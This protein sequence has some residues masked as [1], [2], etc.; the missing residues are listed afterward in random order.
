[1]SNVDDQLSAGFVTT[2]N[3]RT[4]LAEKVEL[5]RDR[6][7]D[8]SNR[9]ALI[10]TRISER[11]S[12]L[13]FDT[14]STEEIWQKL[15]AESE[16][17]ADPMRFPW[18]RDLVPPPPDWQEYEEE[19][20][21]VA[22][23]EGPVSK[24]PVASDESAPTTANSSPKTDNTSSTQKQTSNGSKAESKT[25]TGTIKSSAVSLRKRKRRE[26]NPPFEECKS[27]SLLQPNDL[28]VDKS[29]KVLDRKLR[30]LDS[31]ARLAMSEQGVH[32]LYVAFG[33]LKWYES[34][35]SSDARFSPLMLVPVTLSRDSTSAPWELTEA[36]DDVVSNLCLQ[37]RLWQ[38]FKLEL[39]K[40]PEINELEEEGA[41]K[42][43]LDT[44]A[45][46]IE[47]HERW[48]VV[49]KCL[50][51]RFAF[52]K[53]VMWEDLGAHAE[54]VVEHPLCRAIG[55]DE[56]AIGPQAFGSIGEAPPAKELDDKIS[57]GEIK[58][59]LDCDSSQL[60]AIVAARKGI[61]FVLDGPPGTGKS[62]TIANI[63]A[64]AL[65]VG[66]T[67]LFVS[68]KISALEVVKQRLQ[69]CQLDDFCLECH[70]DKASRRAVLFELERCLDLQQEKYPDW[71]PKLDELAEQRS[72][73]NEYV[74]RIHQPREPLGLSAFMLYGH[75][76]RLMNRGLAQL[77]QCKLPELIDVNRSTFDRWMR[78]LGRASDHQEV[79][80]NFAMHPWRGCKQTTRSLSIH[81]QVKQE[82][83][84][85]SEKLDEVSRLL[86][87]L[88]T[89]ELVGPVTIGNINDTIKACSY[90]ISVPS[91][92]DSWFVAPAETAAA[93]S[94]L[95][96]NQARRTA[97]LNELDQFVDDVEDCFPVDAAKAFSDENSPEVPQ[98]VQGRPIAKSTL[99][100]ERLAEVEQ[101]IARLVPVGKSLRELDEALSE[102]SQL[103]GLS[104]SSPVTSQQLAELGKAA[105]LAGNAGPA[106]P[107]WFSSENRK[108]IRPLAENAET[109]ATRNA[110]L[111]ER[112][113]PVI[114]EE[115]LPV[116]IS[117]LKDASDDTE[118]FSYA[119]D[120]KL[121][122][123]KSLEGAI[124]NLTAALELIDTISVAT[125]QVVE[126][127]GGH[128]STDRAVKPTATTERL[129]AILE[130]IENSGY[131]CCTWRDASVRDSLRRACE[132]AEAD[133]QDATKIRESLS[134]RM[135]HRAFRDSSHSLAKR[136]NDFTSSWSRWSSSFKKYRNELT[137]LYTASVPKG[138]SV[139]EDMALLQKYHS[140]VLEVRELAEELKPHLPQDFISAEP[141]SW[142]Q[143]KAAVTAFSELATVWPDLVASLANGYRSISP[144]KLT[145]PAKRM[146]DALLEYRHLE[147]EKRLGLPNL[148]DEGTSSTAEVLTS[149]KVAFEKVKSQWDHFDEYTLRPIA[150]IAE[151]HEFSTAL[152]KF[153]K[154]RSELNDAAE[155]YANWLPEDSSPSHATTWQAMK[156]GIDAAQLFHSIGVTEQQLRASWGD[157][158]FTKHKMSWH[159]AGKRLENAWEAANAALSS[160]DVDSRGLA[161]G[162][163]AKAVDREINASKAAKA[164][165]ESVTHALRA[166]GNVEIDELA[167]IADQILE[168]REARRAVELAQTKLDNLEV[169]EVAAGDLEAAQWLGQAAADETLSP[170][171]RAV[172]SD[173][174]IRQQVQEILIESRE[175]LQSDGF[176]QAWDL[177][178]S[179]FDLN[180]EVSDGFTISQSSPDK[181]SEKLKWLTTQMSCFDS[182][183]NFAS[184]KR[185][186][187]E[188]G[189]GTVVDELVAQRYK[190]EDAADVIA[191]Q[192]YRQMFDC[193]AQTERAIG[194]FDVDEHERIRERFRF[195]DQ[196]EIKTSASRIR[197]YQLSRND[198]PTNNFWGADSSELGILL[199][200]IAK[201][202]KHK[203]LR[204]LFTEIPTV[205]QR[206]KPCIMMSP[207]SVSTFLNT[208]LLRFDL[209][210]F[211]EASQ[212]F[213]WD[214][215]GAVYR[216]QQLIVAGDD[217]QLPPTNF[218]SRADAETDE[219]EE[220]I[221]DYESILSLCKSIGMPNQRL[222]WH[223]RS[224]REPLIAF[225][226]RHFYDGELVTFPSIYDA[227]GDGVR[228]E[229]VPDG[230][231]MDSKNLKEAERIV[232]MIVE[233]V[234]TRPDK[235][236]GVIALNR[237][238]QK[239]IEDS[240]YDLRRQD[241]EI[242]ALFD[243]GNYF[244]NVAER[245]FVKNLENV[246][247]DER[248]VIFLSMGFGY[249]D[250]G[251]FLKNFG[252]IIRPNGER[253]LNVAV[254]RAREELVFVS[255]VRSSDMDLSGSKSEGA[256]LLKAYL[257]YAEKGVDTLGHAIDEFSAEMD[258]PFEGEV[259]AALI[260][261]GF[262]PV[263]QVGCGGF[264]IDLALKHPDRPGEFCLAIECDGSTY[265]SSDTARDRDRIRQS[266]LENLGWQ[267]IR[268]WSTDWV[269]DPDRQIERVIDAY[270]A[271]IVGSAQKCLPSADTFVDEDLEPEYVERQSPEKP[272]IPQF[273]SIDEVPDSIIQSAAAHILTQAGAMTIDDLIKQT[274]RELG[275]RRLG[276]KIKARIQAQLKD[277]LHTGHL[278]R[279]GERVT[280]GE[281]TK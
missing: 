45:A 151:L 269:R 61:S 280:I 230:R 175:V 63:I 121:S 244:G 93:V 171:V 107:E 212:V 106:R 176:K 227:R 31:D 7:L 102:F 64:D 148:A 27:S 221:S 44:V 2:N 94:S 8:L 203:P 202:R 18:R 42:A 127:F 253:R 78:L 112:L 43:Y 95:L 172:A 36:E 257:S 219:D 237:S 160:A 79:I 39:P 74:R 188:A 15:A 223:Y 162:D 239:T 119:I 266:I 138:A 156:D 130:A 116:L 193:L 25:E 177:L 215:L 23:N 183:L 86:A 83:N 263:P 46:A 40:L 207:L 135:S 233:H 29:D 272:R 206:L 246:Q 111:L 62:Q 128:Q 82:F 88:M 66:R 108:R 170:L 72:R 217:K 274:S 6:L 145:S 57:P 115:R 179:L 28:L 123:R 189:F 198:R 181:L 208:D 65:S 103:T 92:P 20:E 255:S 167:V 174:S 245:L 120:R 259:A 225:S 199:K 80:S 157:R 90:A 241:P 218:F 187:T 131:F 185:D 190:P 251:K 104:S 180:S 216:G 166:D 52:P 35:D 247:G 168:L 276:T 279:L 229:Y 254:T 261:R 59:I 48:E 222:R 117:V 133:L 278:K 238:Q 210:I 38:D 141:S 146:I 98:S 154:R 67:V 209:V 270:E 122:D 11:S 149:Q 19:P 281:S 195:L 147:V 211:D 186:V 205:L 220:D 235:S 243:S 33:F 58:T 250:A 91:T 143:L 182:W 4:T 140:R 30:N 153:D 226:N 71:T 204:R 192:F 228:L 105:R 3:V 5:W 60:E 240:L 51:G 100:R 22:P 152:L 165:L 101:E 85:L 16:A 99:V 155:R 196:L 34:V 142:S 77:T 87:P 76:S 132:N 224:R 139:V 184:W 26:W 136:G 50:L 21:S 231:W 265:H 54:S 47:K 81:D 271:S 32:V 258:S 268:I 262:E 68:E 158:E 10:N 129:I 89:Q 70:S 1:M 110:F 53:I 213:P 12:N 41:R 249:N 17:G 113:S 69:S 273:G 264:R 97:I 169:T 161:L 13:V 159:S 9:N 197:E 178:K 96:T 164:H 201:K 267:V 124:D 173:D 275:F 242:D 24:L 84:T 114:S 234:R 252:P 75:V 144:G 232:E 248:D 125:Q 214:A 118:A 260:R 194:N 163:L 191:V 109:F 236:L 56:E 256:H 134:E 150:S 14:P 126:A 137:E 277:D 37:Q 200:E 49:D 55:G 73:L